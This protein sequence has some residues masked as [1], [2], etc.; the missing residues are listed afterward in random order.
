M[1]YA[2]FLITYGFIVIILLFLF[3]N[4]GKLDGVIA[5]VFNLY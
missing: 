4:F 5:L 2:P 1:V 3:T